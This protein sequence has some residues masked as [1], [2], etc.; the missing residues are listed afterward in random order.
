MKQIWTIALLSLMS[1]ASR[2]AWAQADFYAQFSESEMTNPVSTQYLPGATVGVMLEGPS[3][4]HHVLIAADIQGRFVESS[5]LKLNGAV[6]GPRLSV[7]VKHGLVPYGEFMIGFARLFSNAPGINLN[8]S[9]TDSEI[10]INAGLAKRI[11][12]R[13]DATVDYSYAQYYGLGGMYN[14]KTF[15][16]GAIFHLQKR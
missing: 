16:A 13:C 7:P 2:A 3:V 8:G 6:V 15:S 11:S 4:F 5:S 14:P 9:T 10:Q 12:P 1:I